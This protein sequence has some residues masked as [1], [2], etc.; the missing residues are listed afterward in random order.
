MR[1]DELGSLNG[2]DRI[3]PT[4]RPAARTVMR[5]TWRRLLFLHWPVDASALLPLIPPGLELDHY[6]GQAY[7]GLVPFT[8]T[9]VRP[10]GIPPVGRLSNFHET[11]VRTY[12]HCG[13][14]NPGV[15]F[16]SLDAANAI[17]VQVARR[18]FYLPYYYS[19]MRMTCSRGGESVACVGDGEGN[20]TV[21]YE[22]ERLWPEPT[23]AGCRLRYSAIGSAAPARPGSLEHFLIERYILYST[24]GGRLYSGQVH[25]DPYPVQ[26]A[27]LVR[28]EESLI[29]AA[30]IAVEGPPPLVH[31]AARVDVRI[32]GLV[33]V[34]EWVSEWWRM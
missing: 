14:R 17:A 33:P 7:V 20:V 24:A 4:R 13:G 2:I 30:G 5:Q 25:H 22:A 6:N 1:Q 12:V 29:A 21:D 3:G 10:V 8:M 31:Y 18:L 26:R 16:F 19:R 9:G 28:L 27:E 15:W 11:N 34:S 32:Y 23:P